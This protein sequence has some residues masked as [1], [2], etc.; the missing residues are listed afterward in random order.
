MNM[1]MNEVKELNLCFGQHV[2]P[3]QERKDAKG[4]M[5]APQDTSPVQEGKTQGG[6]LQ[7]L[8]GQDTWGKMTAPQD[9]SPVQEGKA[10]G[11]R[12][13]LLGGQDTWGKMAAP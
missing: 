2:P 10:Q 12:L 6:R 5:T 3:G 7:L 1:N 8:G 13:Q 9:T 11:G 4:N